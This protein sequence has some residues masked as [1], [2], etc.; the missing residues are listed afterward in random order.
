M[1]DYIATFANIISTSVK[2]A[3]KT[4]TMALQGPGTG[5]QGDTGES[6]PEEP[7]WGQVG[8]LARPLPKDSNGSAEAI[9]LRLPDGLAPVAHRDNR[10]TNAVPALEPGQFAMVHYAGG[11]VTV[12][13]LDASNTQTLIQ[14]KTG[15]CE[16]KMD[17]TGL[18][19]INLA[20]GVVTAGDPNT[21]QSMSNYAV[22]SNYVTALKAYLALVNPIVVAAAGPA[23][24]P[25]TAAYGVLQAAET[26][27]L[28]AATASTQVFKAN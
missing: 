20:S 17:P 14:L 2:G 18:G 19:S 6:S 11:F 13:G 3:K 22:L 1:F 4:I 8:I 12:K 7:S 26:A 16:I 9:A 25:I 15:P 21:A 10:L 24:P 27:I 28:T 23:G 5:L